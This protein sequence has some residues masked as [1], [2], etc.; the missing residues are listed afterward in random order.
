MDKSSALSDKARKVVGA[1]RSRSGWAWHLCFPAAFFFWEVVFSVSVSGELLPYSAMEMLLFS[2][3]AGSVVELVTSLLP[4]QKANRVIRLCLL[5]ILSLPYH[6]E[7]FVHCQF[8]VLYDV[9]TVIN[10]AG[11]VARGFMT[12]VKRL[13]FS[14][15][16][17]LFIFLGLLPGI[18]YA[19]FGLRRDPAPRLSLRRAGALAGAVVLTFGIARLLVELDGYSQGLYSDKYSFDAAVGQF[20]LLT[21]IRLDLMLGGKQEELVFEPILPP[22]TQT[23]TAPTEEDSTH[24]EETEPVIYGKN[25]LP[26][27]FSQCKGTESSLAQYVEAL[28]AS[29]KNAYTG[30]FA[31]KNMIFITAEAFTAEVISP[32]LTPTLYRLA[33]S[34][35][36]FTDFYQPTSA[37]TTGGEVLNLLGILPM[38]GGGSMS[39]AV[40]YHPMTLASFL[41]AQGYVGGAFHNNDFTFYNRDWTH[42]RLGYPDGF[43]GY[44]NGAEE[45]VKGQ[46]PQSDREMMEGTLPGYIAQKKPFNLYYM[47][48]SGHSVYTQ[49]NNAMTRKNWDKVKDL[50]YSEKVKCYLACQLEL[51]SALAYT[52][53]ALEDAG[54]ADDTVI[55]I[56][57]D[58][59]P[60][61]LDDSSG[62]GSTPNLD[63]L[64][65]YPVQT[66]LQRDHNRLIL[67]CG[68][69]EKEEPVEISSPVS[70]MDIL[71]TLCN[72]FGVDYDSRLMVGRD[73]FSDQEAL[74]FNTS[75]DWKTELGTYENRTQEFTPADPSAEIPDGYVD[76]ICQTVKNK[77]NYC[78]GVLQCN[79]FG[80]VLPEQIAGSS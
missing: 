13:V 63:E 9:T 23:A 46:W 45:Y 48:V 39:A 11:G 25:E 44:G 26:L 38:Q 10:G 4:W 68:S 5:L 79:F 31:G 35:F 56:S 65:G 32:E 51:E 52:V 36:Q 15:S 1:L 18:L 7:Y 53:E 72:L 60:Y 47:S 64:Y 58:H 62:L 73:V 22:E 70:S 41:T 69:L 49:K 75:F 57:A 55:C 42:N 40:S 76:R 6:I 27:D 71:P 19:V 29:S 78:R 30:L 61:G 8:R 74:V 2:L 28:P 67:W 12:E 33:N 17:L 14:P 3:A 20:G 54:I 59:F 34:G 43:T 66:R 21:G 80:H 16:G 24:P 77:V 37:G 50:S